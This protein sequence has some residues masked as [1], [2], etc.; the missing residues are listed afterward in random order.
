MLVTGTYL[1]TNCGN[2]T[3]QSFETCKMAGSPD[4][5]Q[6]HIPYFHRMMCNWAYNIPLNFQWVLV[7]SAQNKSYLKNKIKQHVTTLEPVG[8]SMAN[9]VDSTL[10]HATQ[11]VI[12]CI[13]AQAISLPGETVNTEHVGV[14]DGSNRGF[15]NAPII[16]GRGNFAALR[17]SFL[18]TNRSFV[19]GV[20]RPWSIVVAHEG[21]IAKQQSIKANIDMYELAKNGECNPT[22]VRKHWHFKDCVP[23]IISE[24]EKTYD[25]GSDYP[26]RQVSFIYNS[27]YVSDMSQ[28]Q[29]TPILSPSNF[30]IKSPTQKTTQN[31]LS[32]EP[33]SKVIDP[34]T[35][36]IA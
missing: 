10:S 20:L 32:I 9:T 30:S 1:P 22:V 13:F 6:S 4:I 16:S 29:N 8:W 5:T 27:Y 24:E 33:N 15:I 12:G 21:L 14:M 35:S 26:K 7:I 34:Q 23:I 19:D 28:E 36:R 18:E 17:T 3:P 11:D 2:I 25:G 31:L